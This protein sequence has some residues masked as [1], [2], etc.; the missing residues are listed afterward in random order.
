ME[1][2]II[3]G[4]INENYSKW[5]KYARYH[6]SKAGI[7]QDAED[8]LHQILSSIILTQSE[9]FLLDLIHQQ[10]NKATGLDLFVFSHIKLNAIFPKSSFRMKFRPVLDYDVKD[11]RIIDVDPEAPSLSDYFTLEDVERMLEELN[12]DKT[13]L[14][15]FKAKISNKSLNTLSTGHSRSFPYKRMKKI[16][17][18]IR[19]NAI[20]SLDRYEQEQFDKNK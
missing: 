2:K 12:I 19:K 20:F 18:K 11:D 6:C 13:D 1:N 15:I 3:D 4:Y 5:L 17:E 16:S 14:N 10:K 7:A 9:T 8:L